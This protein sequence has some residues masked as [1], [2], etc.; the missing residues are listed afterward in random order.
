MQGEQSLKNITVLASADLSASQYCFMDLD[1]NGNAVLPAAGAATVGVNQ[2]KPTALG[3]AMPLALPTSVSKVYAGAAFNAGAQLMV[4]VAGQ[5]IT[6]TTGNFVVGRALAA[7][8]AIGQLVA[9]L[10]V[11]PY[12]I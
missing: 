4:T 6:A 10:L 11:A 12:K 9:V 2:D 3:Q 5:A 1:T 7:A 8:S